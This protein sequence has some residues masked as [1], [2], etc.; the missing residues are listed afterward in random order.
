MISA[1]NI[2]YAAYFLGL[3]IVIGSHVALYKKMTTHAQ[4]NLLAASMIAYYFMW[5]E[6]MIK[7]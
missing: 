4:A 6:G 1:A 3:S 5:R 2:H 7:F